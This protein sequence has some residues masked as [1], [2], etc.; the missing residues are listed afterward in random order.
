MKLNLVV[1]SQ[2]LIIPKLCSTQIF[3]LNPRY[4][5]SDRKQ[6]NL[7]LWL[8]QFFTESGLSFEIVETGAFKDLF[9]KMMPKANIL[10]EADFVR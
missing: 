1:F 2:S 10:S 3:V 5:T 4:V 9:L 6:L 8:T 7:D